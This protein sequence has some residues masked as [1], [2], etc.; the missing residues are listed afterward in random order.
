MAEVM[1]YKMGGK[2]K[3]IAENI[4]TDNSFRV[5]LF[6]PAPPRV[7]VHGSDENIGKDEKANE[8][9]IMFFVH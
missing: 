8:G 2:V 5:S 6:P 4:P 9:I 1:V 7:H 3:V